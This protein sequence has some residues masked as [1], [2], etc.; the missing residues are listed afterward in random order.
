MTRY[1]NRN[2][3]SIKN[4]SSL[5][6]GE[7]VLCNSGISVSMF[8]S[9]DDVPQEN[10]NFASNQP[11]LFLQKEYLSVVEKNPPLGMKFC[12]FFFYRENTPI[13]IAIGQIQYFKANQSIISNENEGN[14]CFFTTFFRFLRGLVS[15][16]AEFNIL[17]N[18]SLLLTGEHG[19][20]F[21]PNVVSKG[22]G[23]ELLHKAGDYGM[24]ILQ[25]KGEK[26]SGILI[27]DFHEKNLI[28]SR[29][30][31][32]LGYNEFTVQPSMLMDIRPEWK[33]F[34]DYMDAL[35]SKYR[36]RVRRAFKKAANI[37]K[38][39]FDEEM[40]HANLPQLY[41]LYLNIAENSGFNMV[42]LNDTYLL[43]LKK[44]FPDR[45]RMITYYLDDKLIGYFTTI[46]NGD[47]LEA[48]F[49]GFEPKYN[50]DLQIYLNILYDMVRIGI[51]SG[52]RQ[53]VFA[54][55]AMAIKSSVGAVAHEMYC[56][57]RHRNS[58]PNKFIKP[59]L[60][61]LRPEKDWEPRHPFK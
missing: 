15:S 39:E 28:Q 7:R 61:Y 49:L 18:G 36:V 60:H 44:Q 54:R 8:R 52:A 17:V 9:V 55:T 27:K 58:F 6:E 34:D 2:Q 38:R 3:Q 47:E 30:L 48:H 22:K 1:E 45:F 41:Q 4:V 14:P 19:F 26:L 56:Y 40:I 29:K 53:I 37:E 13:G 42:N 32:D 31:I 5:L 16:H 20:Y 46:L 50:H 57:M 51:D 10:W 21:D 59:I 33:T 12:Y 24:E 35:H 43:G 11:N 23:F 25:K